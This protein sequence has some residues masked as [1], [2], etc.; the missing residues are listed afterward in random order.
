MTKII[1]DARFADTKESLE[2]VSY[3]TA[4]KEA[5]EKFHNALAFAPKSG[6]NI[7]CLNSI[8]TKDEITAKDFVPVIV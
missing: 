6:V 4:N 5:D 3:M 7:I 1:N 2:D 8:V